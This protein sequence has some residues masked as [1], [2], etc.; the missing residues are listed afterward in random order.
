MDQGHWIAWYNLPA[1][2][3]DAYLSWLHGTY[4]PKLLKKPGILYAAHYASAKVPPSPLIP[5]TND[6]SVPTGND[7]VLI[8]GAETA[9][10]FSKGADAFISKCRSGCRISGYLTPRGCRGTLRVPRPTSKSGKLLGR[11]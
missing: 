3:R 9:H 7:Y 6:H 8:F 1:E 4:I 10:A 5:H 2:G 11:Y